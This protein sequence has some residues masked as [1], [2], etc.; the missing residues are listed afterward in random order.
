MNISHTLRANQSTIST[1]KHKPSSHFNQIFKLMIK[2]NLSAFIMITVKGAQLERFNGFVDEI[3]VSSYFYCDFRCIFI[4]TRQ[5][6]F[7]YQREEKNT[8]NAEK[9]SFKH[10]FINLWIS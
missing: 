8:Q 10:V 5:I 3:H 9:E 2:T 4:F 1:F 6:S 7:K